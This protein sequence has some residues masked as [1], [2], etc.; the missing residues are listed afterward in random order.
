[1]HC[2]SSNYQCQEIY[3]IITLR[4]SIHNPPPIRNEPKMAIVSKQ[5]FW[6]ADK[7]VA[8]L[9]YKV[10]DAAVYGGNQLMIYWH[11]R[12]HRW[13]FTTCAQQRH[14]TS[15]VLA[16]I[17]TNHYY[18][19][20]KLLLSSIIELL[21]KSV[22]HTCQVRP[23]IFFGS[24]R[25]NPWVRCIFPGSSFLRNFCTYDVTISN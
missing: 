15:C 16:N 7:V 23:L 19:R 6:Y 24:L 13:K 8:I 9:L 4:I 22:L 2:H 3:A 11:I 14:G 1:M 5:N 20:K 18:H 25:R 10:R 12:M 17:G 21:L